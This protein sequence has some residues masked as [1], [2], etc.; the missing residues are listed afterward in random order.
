MEDKKDV[1]LVTLAR[2]GDLDAFGC[3]FERYQGHMKSLAIRTLENEEIALE[4]VQ[5]ALLQS[6][7]SIHNLKD[8]ERFKSWL[9]GIVVN[10]C[11]NYMR[12]EHGKY[13]WVEEIPENI[14]YNSAWSNLDDPETLTEKKEAQNQF[15]LL[16]E[17]LKPNY[18]RIVM[19]YYF[20]QMQLKEIGEVE[21]ITLQTAKVRL[22]RARGL[23]RDKLRLLYPELDQGILPEDRRK[24]MLLVNVVDVINLSSEEG[25]IVLLLDEPGNKIL[26]IWIG[27]FEGLSIAAGLENLQTPRPL[28]YRWVASM[29]DALGT[30]LEEVRIEGLK[31]D[32]YLG[33]M[34]IRNA[35]RLVELDARPSDLIALAVHKGTPVYVGEELMIKTGIDLRTVKGKLQ[36]FVGV[37]EI[38]SEFTE[39]SRSLQ[40]GRA[41]QVGRQDKRDRLIEK[42]FGTQ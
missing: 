35:D 8:A 40:E 9:Y 13:L 27:M 1:E 16:I 22:H 6:F 36:P 42:I 32:T 30:E 19:L 24:T 21:G 41:S 20:H 12:R 15:L 23:L 3:L 25:C 17:S 28:T 14:L 10:L 38:I 26:P 7:L 39:V 11:R 34:V 29:L 2:L 31:E 18:R 5:E 4:M 33:T 37:R